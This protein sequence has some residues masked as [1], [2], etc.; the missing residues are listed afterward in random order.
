VRAS[1]PSV[2]RVVSPTAAVPAPV[3][4]ATWS[5][6]VPAPVMRLVTIAFPAWTN[7]V[8]MGRTYFRARTGKTL[9]V[10]YGCSAR[11]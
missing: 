2:K 11:Y 9:P 8:A 6:S 7:T 5:G 3:P 10:A 1:G 4:Q